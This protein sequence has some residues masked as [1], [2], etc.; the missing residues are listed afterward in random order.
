MASSPGFPWPVVVAVIILALG[1][2]P[3]A[4]WIGGGHEMPQYPILLSEWS[5]GTLL[6]MGLGV[7][8]AILSRRLPLWRE[9]LL[10]RPASWCTRHPWIFGESLAFVALAL[11]A[12]V[13]MRV[14]SSRPLLID[15][16]AQ[17]FQARIF[18]EGRTW[19]PTSELV[20]LSSF[21]HV[22]DFDGRMYSQFPPGWPALLS[23][24]ARG[25]WT[26][27][28]APLSA[29]AAVS[30]YWH[31]VRREEP[32]AGV[33]VG[34]A[35][36]FAFAPFAVFMSGSH[37]NHV[38]AMLCVCTVLFGLA[39]ATQ[40]A[41]TTPGP[42][43]SS[44]HNNAGARW[45]HALV[46]FGIG[47]LA[48]M[49]PVDAMAFGLPTIA[50][51]AFGML[52][53]RVRAALI[54]GAAG[55]VPVA[56]LL[57]Y[58]SRTTGHPLLLGYSLLWGETHGLGFHR[59]PWGF[60]HTPAR[61]LELINLYLVRL[62]TYFL[63]TPVPSLVPAAIALALTKRFTTFDRLL[64]AS[65]GSILVAYFAYWHDGFY[66]GPRF[67]YLLMPALALWTA[68]LIPVVRDRFKDGL[69]LR[70][71]TWTAMASIAIGAMT[72]V[73]MRARQ[74]SQGMLSMRPSYA[75]VADA[76]GVEDAVVIVRESWGAQLVAR[77]WALGIPRSETE[78]LYRGIDACILETTIA[79]AEQRGVR[80][81]EALALFTPLL[82]DA[83]RLIKSPWS[84]DDTERA[85]PGLTY[86]PLCQQRIAEDLRGFTHLA[87]AFV[88]DQGSNR[89]Y[90]DLHVK[91]APLLERHAGKQFYL[92]KPASPD[93]GA[94]LQLIKLPAD[95]LRAA[96]GRAE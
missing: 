86:A 23:L 62:Q 60:A 19:L 10:Q 51:Y 43:S 13:S 38:G 70:T 21:M 87:P 9:G 80:G 6:A 78:G 90:R 14:F 1:L 96:W 56:A 3:I 76:A 82:I 88:E 52:R 48:T 17:V 94:P 53:G 45:P 44:G 39:R 58:N 41:A 4:N 24:G 74:Y 73:P 46:G 83:P 79:D 93:I 95:S 8:L 59:A 28:V 12:F 35:V 5:S 16:I 75:Q 40:T 20:P 36:L 69:V 81:A 89:F 30:L 68:R 65:S 11:Y 22:L 72:G 91:N 33:A 32:R 15:E 92:L 64:L 55:L 29:A 42:E 85:L 49:R 31:A 71:V 34:A 18:A 54:A 27:L 57:W 77:L 66:L 25:G 61:G 67:V 84:P 7:V 63:E 47:A 26:W 37:M 2:L 50:W